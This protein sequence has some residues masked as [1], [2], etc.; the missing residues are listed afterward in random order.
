[1]EKNLSNVL[2]DLS[3]DMADVVRDVRRSPEVSSKS[4]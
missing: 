4:V 2:Q 3:D 1:M